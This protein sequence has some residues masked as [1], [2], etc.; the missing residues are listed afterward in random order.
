MEP[1]NQEEGPQS[2]LEYTADQHE[3]PVEGQIRG[4]DLHGSCR[5]SGG[6]TLEF[7]AIAFTVSTYF[8]LMLRPASWLALLSRTF[9]FELA[10]IQVTLNQRRI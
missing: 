4:H 7:A 10:P 6:Y 8:V 3:K 2:N 5:V 9:T 1:G